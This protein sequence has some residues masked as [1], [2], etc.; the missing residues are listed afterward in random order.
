[1]EKKKDEEKKETLMS[2]LLENDQE[3]IQDFLLR[4]GKKKSYCPI[5]FKK[6]GD[7][8]FDVDYSN[9]LQKSL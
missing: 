8:N 2:L 6:D 5:Y 1:M 4:N 7:N 9:N 3:K